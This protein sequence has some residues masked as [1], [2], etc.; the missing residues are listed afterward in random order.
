MPA[1]GCPAGSESRGPW[2]APSHQTP[3]D[4][5]ESVAPSPPEAGLS[6]NGRMDG[7]NSERRKE[8]DG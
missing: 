7:E 1:E 5:R 3:H 6:W 2:R 8:G 4:S